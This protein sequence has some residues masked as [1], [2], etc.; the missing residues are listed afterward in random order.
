MKLTIVNCGD[1]G[2]YAVVR[3]QPM[4]P[5]YIAA[6][7]PPHWQIE[8]VDENWERFDPRD[9]RADLVA[10]S[11]I[12]RHVH[13]AYAHAAVLRERGITTVAGGLHVSAVPD[14]ALEH[15]DS[16]VEG[17]AEPLWSTVLADLEHGR[18]QRHY[19][20]GFDRPLE[21]LGLP[22]RRYI[23]PGYKIASVSTSRACN[24]SCSFCY[25]GSL[26][27][28]SYRTIP[29]ETVV[30]DFRQ[31]TQKLIVLT[32]ANFLG[33]TDEHLE[34][35][36]EL[37]EAL[38]RSGIKKYWAAQITADVVRHPELLKLLYRAG[39]RLAFIGFE[40]VGQRALQS[41][42][43]DQYAPLDYTEVV[44]RVQAAGIGVAAS[45][46]LGLDTHDRSYERELTDWLDEARPLF[47]NLGVLTPMPN[48][49]L[50]QQARRDGRLLADGADLWPHIDKATTT[51]RYPHLSADEVEE[52]FGNV[53]RHF[54]SNRS[55]LR[56]FAN[57]LFVRRQPTLSVLYLASA[58][59]KRG[60]PCKT[61]I[62]P[63]PGRAAAGMVN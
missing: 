14:E 48:T 39:C 26:R 20:A 12:P 58:L 21:T 45:L 60:N 35:R 53:V 23:H 44:R 59:R 27:D 46:I 7:T 24:N 42:D 1:P 8:L 34:S 18:L 30:E 38:I 47:L 3:Y 29:A 56:T 6:C 55:I 52:M 4:A 15:F 36:L 40:T 13:R 25:M 9:C 51:L 37:C 17:E 10:F 57:Q 54:F 33:F 11:A 32:D 49:A 43:K 19:R 5:P 50:Y 61:L 31:V 63:D 41:I 16:V 28:R 2:E 22:D 62:P